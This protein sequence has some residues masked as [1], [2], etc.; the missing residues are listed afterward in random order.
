MKLLTFLGTGKYSFTVYVWQGQ[1]YGS[2]F[3][4][5]A[6]CH[7]L[8][9]EGL[10][11][12]LTEEA[13]QQHYADLCQALP[14]GLE[15]QPIAIPPGRNEEELWE[16]FAQVSG[17]V[18]PGEEVAFDITHGLRSLPMVGLLVAAFLRMGLN[19]PLRAVL[20]GAYEVRQPRGEADCTPMFDL[21]PMLSLLEWAA[22]AER[23]NRTGDARLLAGL[24]EGEHR[25]LAKK[26]QGDRVQLATLRRLSNL[27]GALKDISQSLRLIRPQR[28]MEKIAG[29]ARCLAE[30]Q[31][32]LAYA[33]AARPFTLLLEGVQQAYQPL[34]LS[35]PAAPEEAGL[36]LATQKAMIRWYL[37]R[38]QWVQAVTLAREW[39]V[40]WA[41]VQQGRRRILNQ[42]ERAAVEQALGAEARALFLSQQ[43][44]GGRAA[45]SLASLPQREEALSLWL[46]LGQVRNDIDHAGMREGAGEPQALLKQIQGCIARLDALPMPEV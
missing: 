6:S 23:F 33:P 42:A 21:S 25:A 34:G 44:E 45:L 46:A 27:A 17:A 40:S 29:L 12:F 22:A 14:E 1:E 11:V 38:E 2:R 19:V 30:A 7:F 18:R 32:A 8:Q 26:A 36:A 39:L 41:M 4:P 35:N 10:I 31:P 43:E 20:Y 15:V 3:A 16:I 28:A 37:E 5:A 24:L 13:R 9:P